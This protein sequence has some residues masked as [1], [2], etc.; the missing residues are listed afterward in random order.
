MAINILIFILNNDYPLYPN[1]PTLQLNNV[2]DNLNII[3]L[4]VKLNIFLSIIRHK[5]NKEQGI[6]VPFEGWL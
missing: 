3:E 2:I 4:V 5:G 1:I 6:I